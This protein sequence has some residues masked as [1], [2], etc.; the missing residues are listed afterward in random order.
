MNPPRTGSASGLPSAEK[1][2]ASLIGRAA[3]LTPPEHSDDWLLPCCRQC[4]A[5]AVCPYVCDQALRYAACQ[6]RMEAQR[7]TAEAGR[8]L[9]TAAHAGS[10]RCLLNGGWVME[11][12]LA[13]ALDRETEQINH[14]CAQGASRCL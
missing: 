4:P 3:G 14:L 12:A 6:G 10:V 2:S 1:G 11:R 5:R 8:L 7:L 13:H 9:E